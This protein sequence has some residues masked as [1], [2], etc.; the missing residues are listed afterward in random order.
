MMKENEVK[1]LL[2]SVNIIL[3]FKKDKRVYKCLICNDDKYNELNQLYKSKDVIVTTIKLICS[4]LNG[5][6]NFIYKYIFSNEVV[7]IYGNKEFNMLRNYIIIHDDYQK[8]LKNIYN[9]IFKNN[10]KGKEKLFYLI[11]FYELLN[12]KMLYETINSTNDMNFFLEN[13]E[14]IK[15]NIPEFENKLINI[16]KNYYS[17]TAVN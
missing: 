9:Y 15:N 17:E 16:Y 7:C 4:I 10:I 12:G 11:I 13:N 6:Y 2:K 5:K 3:F 14:S 1:N 8:N